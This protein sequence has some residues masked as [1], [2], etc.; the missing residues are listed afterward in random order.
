MVD[1]LFSDWKEEK[2]FKSMV[3]KEIMLESWNLEMFDKQI[4]QPPSSVRL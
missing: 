4:T 1:Q 3:A 2:K